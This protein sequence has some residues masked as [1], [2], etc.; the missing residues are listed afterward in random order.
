MDLEL[1]WKKDNR[2]VVSYING[3]ISTEKNCTVNMNI[4]FNLQVFNEK[5]KKMFVEIKNIYFIDYKVV[6]F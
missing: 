4:D 6:Y 2:D 1:I 3:N 5:V